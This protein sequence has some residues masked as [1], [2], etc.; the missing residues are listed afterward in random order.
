MKERKKYTEQ[1]LG[2]YLRE[3][4]ISPTEAVD[5]IQKYKFKESQGDNRTYWKMFRF[6]LYIWQRYKDQQKN[7]RLP[8]KK[9]TITRVVQSAK[10]K[11]LYDT[12]PQHQFN[13][14]AEVFNL[15]KLV[16]DRRQDNAFK[17]GKYK[18]EGSSKVIPQG[19]IDELR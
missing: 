7:R 14:R 12:F 16:G 2:R 9:D 11:R 6:T 1:E 17:E 19:H 13:E 5:I 10:F 18:Y 15:L 3:N 4:R 8:T